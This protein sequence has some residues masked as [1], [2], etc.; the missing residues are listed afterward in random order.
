MDESADGSVDDGP[1]A[2]PG[3]EDL[4]AE[5]D[6]DARREELEAEAANAEGAVRF[7]LLVEATACARGD[8][9]SRLYSEVLNLDAGDVALYWRAGASPQAGT[10]QIQSIADAL[11]R[12]SAEREDE[13]AVTAHRLV[14][15]ATHLEEARTVDF[16][17]RDLV[18]KSGDPRVVDWQVQRLI[19]ANKWR[20][21][22]QILTEQHGGDPAD[23]RL[24]A[25][26]QMA[27][28]ATDRL[29]DPVKAAD[30]WKQVYQVDRDDVEARRALLVAYKAAGK[31]KDYADILRL[32]VAIPAEMLKGS[33]KA[34]GPG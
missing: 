32:E 34:C 12:L 16:K 9:W 3:T 25:L 18:K 10:E 8:D 23:A 17:L 26:R 28:L 27:H 19:E 7:S 14:F 29:G 15:G 20:N 24:S 1:T 13:P 33:L 21:V 31:W 5:V 4:E 30:F 11:D 22:Q 6:L 2:E